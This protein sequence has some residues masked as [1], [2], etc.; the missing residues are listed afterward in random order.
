MKQSSGEFCAKLSQI[1]T[2]PYS[3]FFKISHMCVSVCMCV[4]T[5]IFSMKTNGYISEVKIVVKCLHAKVQKC[6]GAREGNQKEKGSP[7]KRKIISCL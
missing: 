3:F 5:Y 6:D 4:C 7:E 1:F 2:L